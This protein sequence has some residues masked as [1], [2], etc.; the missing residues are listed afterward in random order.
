VS[1]YNQTDNGLKWHF[2]AHILERVAAIE[3]AYKAKLL[4]AMKRCVEATFDAA[5]WDGMNSAS[6]Q[7]RGK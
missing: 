7:T 6:S 1:H 5:K 2:K 4:L 3:S